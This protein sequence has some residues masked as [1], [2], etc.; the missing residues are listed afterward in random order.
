V[1][2]TT[3]LKSVLTKINFY[4]W[5]KLHKYFFGGVVFGANYIRLLKQ[6]WTKVFQK[7]F[8]GPQFVCSQ[9]TA[10]GRHLHA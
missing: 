2:Q 7:G 8:I 6:P 10:I 4:M 3:T 5:R 1:A 9:P